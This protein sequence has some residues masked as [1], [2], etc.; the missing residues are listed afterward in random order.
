MRLAWHWWG[1]DV[2]LNKPLLLVAIC[3][4]LLTACEKPC[5]GWGVAPTSG[6]IESVVMSKHPDADAKLAIASGEHRLVGLFAGWGISFPGLDCS[7]DLTNA[8]D[9]DRFCLHGDAP[10]ECETGPLYWYGWFSDAKAHEC[11]VRAEEAFIGYATAY[12]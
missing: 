12:N 8:A 6:S 5:D 11:E 10:D 7:R 9:R 4:P 2:Q 1:G 3:L